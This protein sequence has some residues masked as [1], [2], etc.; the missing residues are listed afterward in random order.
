MSGEQRRCGASRWIRTTISLT[1]QNAVH[2]PSGI[3]LTDL[4]GR[5]GMTKQAMAEP[6]AEIER[7]GYLQRTTD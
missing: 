5:A 4:A 1:A 3:R 7:R 2:P 6:V